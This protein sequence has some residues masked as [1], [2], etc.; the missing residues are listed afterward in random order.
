MTMLYRATE[1]AV[2]ES[3]YGLALARVVPLPPKVLKDATYFAHKLE[4]RLLQRRKTSKNV[5]NERRRKLILDLKE[6][7]VQAHNGSMDGELLSTWLK[8]LQREFV[9]RMTAINED[10]KGVVESEDDDDDD[11][12]NMQDEDLQDEEMLDAEQ[13]STEE[14]QDRE[15]TLHR[16]LFII[17]V[18]SKVS[19]S[20]DES[21]ATMRRA[22]ESLSEDESAGILRRAS[23]TLSEV[24]AVSENMF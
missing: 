5:I 12:H 17:S 9:N 11:R 18:S 3:H 23:E 14:M 4:R 19:S 2:Q 15:E 20:E 1:G 10:E 7:L 22:S 13:Q 6:H 24:R 16:E 21:I 8:E